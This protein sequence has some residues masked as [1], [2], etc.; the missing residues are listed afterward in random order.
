MHGDHIVNRC[1]NVAIYDRIR[2]HKNKSSKLRLRRFNGEAPKE[3]SLPCSRD[4][5]LT[6]IDWTGRSIRND[7]RGHIDHALP[8]ILKRWNM[9]GRSASDGNRRTGHWLFGWT[10]GVEE[11]ICTSARLVSIP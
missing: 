7:K 1:H 6:L 3:Q 10:G 8:P 9:A 5:Y 4:D 11:I 2:E